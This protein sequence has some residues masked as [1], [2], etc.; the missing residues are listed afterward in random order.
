MGHG[1]RAMDVTTIRYNGPRVFPAHIGRIFRLTEVGRIGDDGKRKIGPYYDYEVA[2]G[3]WVQ[4]QGAALICREAALFPNAAECDYGPNEI[5][6]LLSA[7][8]AR[9]DSMT[10]NAVLI[11]P[12]PAAAGGENP[13]RALI[14]R[15]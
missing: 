1:L 9:T 11:K 7:S 12:A 8:L 15:R 5:S 2:Y 6:F 3:E 10:L 13:L 4:D 14:G